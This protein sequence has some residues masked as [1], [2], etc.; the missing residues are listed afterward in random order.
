MTRRSWVQT[1]PRGPWSK[2]PDSKHFG[3]IPK[4]I[5]EWRERWDLLG[6]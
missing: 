4:N 6:L 1:N 3:I 5:E 2:N